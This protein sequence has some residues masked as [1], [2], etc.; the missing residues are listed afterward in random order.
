MTRKELEAEFGPLRPDGITIR[1]PGKFEGEPLYIGIYY[2]AM[3]NGHGE[4]L[5]FGLEESATVFEVSEE[6]RRE[7]PELEDVHAVALWESDQGF[8]NL[9][10][11]EDAEALEEYRAKAEAASEA[12]EGEEED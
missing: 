1:G 11:F 4:P 9:E 6:D 8:E 2:D 5:D 3:M 7:F 12:A 10:E